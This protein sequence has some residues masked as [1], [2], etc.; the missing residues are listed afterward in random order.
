[1]NTPEFGYYICDRGMRNNPELGIRYARCGFNSFA[2]ADDYC[3]TDP[4]YIIIDSL[5]VVLK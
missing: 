3:K 5:G 2:D 4:R 1:M